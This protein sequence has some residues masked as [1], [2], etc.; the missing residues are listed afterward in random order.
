MTSIL[1]GKFDGSSDLATWLREF[2]RCSL[3]N[4]WKEQ[5]KV[6]KL[7]AVYKWDLEKKL[8]KA[9]PLLDNQSKEALLLHQFMRGLLKNLKV[10]M[11]ENDPTPTLTDM[12]TFVQW[13]YAVQG[14]G[15]PKDCCD[16]AESSVSP[17]DKTFDELVNMVNAK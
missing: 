11:L 15:G 3:A 5:D 2:D 14:Q 17:Q 1:P 13:Y 8:L 9:D 7:P 10:K 12:V 4:N 6:K 16:V